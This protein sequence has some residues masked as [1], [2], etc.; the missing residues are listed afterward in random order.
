MAKRIVIPIFSSKYNSNYVVRS[1]AEPIHHMKNV[2]PMLTILDTT[3]REGELQPGLYFTRESRIQ[4]A[5]ALA[6]I[7]TRRIEFPIAYPNRGVPAR[8][9]KAA[10]YEVQENFSETIA[11]LQFRALQEDIA[12]A[13]AYDA[14]GCAVY[15]APTALHRKGKLHGINRQ[16][17]IERFVDVLGRAKDSGF[18]YRRAVLEDVS[19][20][21]SP[22][23][24]REDTQGYLRRLL[25]AL[26]E[27]GA[28]I[29]SVPDTSGL[30]P[31]HRCVGFIECLA[32]EAK[33]PLACHFHNDYGNALGNA[34]QAALIP[35]VREIHV[36]IMGLGTRNGI[37][38]HYEFVANL[39][40][41]YRMSTGEHRDK[42]HWLYDVFKKVTRLPLPWN[43]PLSP[44]S[45][46]E[47]AG[48][49]QSQVVQ[50]PRGY[51]PRGKLTHDSVGDVRF[52]AGQMMSKQVVRK[53]LGTRATYEALITEVTEDIAA[54]SAL[55]GR[56]VSP[57]EVREII[58]AKTGV[59]L[60]VDD[61]REMIKGS[62]YV[63]VL[64]SLIPQY[65]ARKLVTEIGGWSEVERVDETYGD[66]DVVVVS[67][68]WDQDGMP[69]VDKIRKRFRDAILTT[70]TLPVE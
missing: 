22:E 38:D 56:N 32:E 58:L 5:Q 34:L 70:K 54:R 4:I 23:K 49:H 14:K 31:P 1:Q 44:Q 51:I 61:V 16:R 30:L 60:P 48:T 2:V 18:S 50:D 20:F 59:D 55:K 21:Y 65:P 28:T 3:L 26:R 42:L 27:G 43:H 29:V 66:V 62:D 19:R 9:I 6:T 46:T 63:Y 45:F 7:G 64:L 69:V 53:L 12:L 39:E 41:L 35:R 24:A 67:S 36:S 25:E 68:M 8:D 17:V 57:L 15:L 33:L 10:V 13:S 40:D 37:T 47:K 11:V 52:E